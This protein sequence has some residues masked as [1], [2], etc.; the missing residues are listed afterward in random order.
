[1]SENITRQRRQADPDLRINPELIIKIKEFVDN[2]PTLTQFFAPGTNTLPSRQGTQAPSN[3]RIH[4]SFLGTQAGKDIQ[5]A[6]QLGQP[7]S[8]GNN[9][10]TGVIFT[11][12]VNGHASIPTYFGFTDTENNSPIPVTREFFASSPSDLKEVGGIAALNLRWGRWD[13]ALTTETKNIGGQDV[14]VKVPTKDIHFMYTEN[15]VLNAAQLQA[16]VA[17]SGTVNLSYSGGTNPTDLQGN[18]GVIN[19]L[20]TT[21]ELNMEMGTGKLSQFTIKSEF[22]P[23]GSA[24]HYYLEMAP[25]D[26]SDPTSLPGPV[27]FSDII[28]KGGAISLTGNCSNAG[29][30]ANSIPITGNASADFIANGNQL[31][32]ISSFSAHDGN[33]NT[34]AAATVG[35]AGTALFSGGG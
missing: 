9:A 11:D 35:V 30:C 23:S 4:A 33:E 25:E 17:N 14:T 13:N 28:G 26:P 22:G 2:D 20:Y 29:A 19:P 21:A 7:N 24:E 3:A 27:K 32:M 12:T 34:G 31:Y 18:V 6:F 15:N 8:T 10:E 16:I 5:V 1:M